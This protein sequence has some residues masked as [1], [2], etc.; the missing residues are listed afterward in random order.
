LAM[1]LTRIGS[2]L[3]AAV[4]ASRHNARLRAQE[5]RVAREHSLRYRATCKECAPPSWRE[6]IDA[7]IEPVIACAA[8]VMLGW[9]LHKWM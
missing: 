2:T 1:E 8:C 5:R 9:L 3:G 6:R 4:A 7:S